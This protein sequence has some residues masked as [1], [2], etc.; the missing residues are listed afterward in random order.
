[1]TER[2]VQDNHEIDFV[3]FILRFRFI[4]L[5]VEQPYALGDTVYIYSPDKNQR[6]AFKSEVVGFFEAGAFAHLERNNAYE[7]FFIDKEKRKKTIGLA[8]VKLSVPLLTSDSKF[9]IARQSG[10]SLAPLFH[11]EQSG[12]G[13]SDYLSVGLTGYE[14]CFSEIN[15]LYSQRGSVGLYLINHCDDSQFCN[16]LHLG[17]LMALSRNA[18]AQSFSKDDALLVKASLAMIA[19]NFYKGAFW[20]EVKRRYF[21]LIQ[22]YEAVGDRIR[23]QANWEG[24]I[25]EMLGKDVAYQAG[26]DYVSVPILMAII[27]R[28]FVS[29]FY[30]LVWTAVYKNRLSFT[31]EIDN[32]EML[33]GAVDSFLDSLLG[34]TDQEEVAE[35]SLL[36][37]NGSQQA[38]FKVSKY[39]IHVLERGLY[40]ADVK[41]LILLVLNKMIDHRYYGDA[42]TAPLCPLLE[43]SFA[44]W[45]DSHKKYREYDPDR[46]SPFE[47]AERA[48]YL[49]QP[50]L[51]LRD[52][53]VF[54]RLP[55]NDFSADFDRTLL[56]IEV[57]D[58]RGQCLGSLGA[59][60]LEIYDLIS[61]K[62]GARQYR[63]NC[64]KKVLFENCLSGFSYRYYGTD[65]LQHVDRQYLFFDDAGREILPY[66]D[67]EGLC[68]AISRSP[69]IGIDKIAETK[70]EKTGYFHTTFSI[71]RNTSFRIGTDWLYFNA[72][73]KLGIGDNPVGNIKGRTQNGK[74][75]NLYS[76]VSSFTFEADE[77]PE[78]IEWHLDDA[79]TP[80]SAMKFT[81]IITGKSG[82]NRYYVALPSPLAPGLHKMWLSNPQGL[83]LDS[84]LLEDRIFAID[85]DLSL[86][87]NPQSP[88]VVLRSTFLGERT[89]CFDPAQTELVI[90]GF[91]QESSLIL[92]NPL[93]RYRLDGETPAVIQ[94]S[95][96][97]SSSL[98]N[99][100]FLE[101]FS[102]FGTPTLSLFALDSQ[103]VKTLNLS[104]AGGYKLYLPE[105]RSFIQA[106][107]IVE[108]I[109]HV[110][111]QTDQVIRFYSIPFCF[112]NGLILTL[113][114]DLAIPERA[115]L[116]VQGSYQGEGT[117]QMAIYRD[118]ENAPCLTVPLTSD[119]HQ[120]DLTINSI[121]AN[122]SWRIRFIGAVEE[123]L[124]S[125]RKALTAVVEERRISWTSFAC[126]RVGFLYP[127]AEAEWQDDKG[128][129]GTYIFLAVDQKQRVHATLEILRGR[130][131]DGAYLAM[132]HNTVFSP[133]TKLGP[134]VLKLIKDDQDGT[135]LL[136]IET[137][138]GGPVFAFAYGLLDA[139]KSFYN[140]RVTSL[141]LRMRGDTLENWEKWRKNDV[142]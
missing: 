118:E 28:Y 36:L 77:S 5:P 71:D 86:Q 115:A 32:Q 125:E 96:L 53:Q 134:V 89:L 11:P 70:D 26:A 122:I 79:V 59:E 68:F 85:P 84:Y 34:E 101:V 99:R 16:A 52:D 76:S 140:K 46:S 132:V 58:G 97:S 107:P 3:G 128:G 110:A 14:D 78:Q 127:I 98:D 41:E 73:V 30:D 95:Q 67:F 35:N 29:E 13:L 105:C 10:E 133:E 15:A 131:E 113:N 93:L 91:D 44:D 57:F 23:P 47:K 60:D 17:S 8:H 33:G 21:N 66:H 139:Q 88:V 2:F 39:T 137:Q 19:V 6:F 72:A 117:F 106:H 82:V 74:D 40:R 100:V 102:V 94:G 116:R 54:I 136:Q 83:V 27:Q 45:S 124:F 48:T 65:S 87:E 90:P 22:T 103:E 126:L 56:R 121:N 138:D 63:V 108:L 42:R 12:L 1:M 92:L 81:T 64:G 123:D 20:E 49:Q 62:N 37:Y 109:V 9:L 38:R 31:D 50:R 25:R 111:G 69:L 61:G 43:N 129:T 142:E 75:F 4:C 24:T 120:F 114:K 130:N 18:S 112:E 51:L 141:L 55:S 135:C 7:T 104:T 80:L 119:Q